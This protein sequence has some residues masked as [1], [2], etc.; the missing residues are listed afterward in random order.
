MCKILSPILMQMGFLQNGDIVSIADISWIRENY[1][2]F[3]I[4]ND[5]VIEGV[6]LF[7]AVKVTIEQNTSSARYI[8]SVR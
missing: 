5:S 3:V 6:N 8:Y 1:K 7:P 4:D 2:P